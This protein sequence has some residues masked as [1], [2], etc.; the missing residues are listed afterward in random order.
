MTVSANTAFELGRDVLIRRACQLAGLLEASQTMTGDDIS[1]AADL[2]QVE[3]LALQTEGVVV[4]HVERTTLTLVAGT[5]EYTLPADTLDVAISPDNVVGTVYVSGGNETPVAAIARGDYQMISMKTTQG[6]PTTAFIERGAT[7][8]VV[9]WPVPS[10]ASTL[11]YSRMRLPRDNDTGIVTLDLARRWQKAIMLSLAYNLA[12]AKSAPLGRVKF[13][14]DEA[15]RQKALARASDVE[16][17][18]MQMTIGG[19]Y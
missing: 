2:L 18:H 17:V 12:L 8:K 10:A 16:K 1:L 13:L 14:F 19:P 5:A 15:E 4:T 11:R 9:L 6:T 3:L 7:V